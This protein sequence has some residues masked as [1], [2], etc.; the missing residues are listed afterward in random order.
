MEIRARHKV[1]IQCD[2]DI[3]SS[4][5]ALHFLSYDMEQNPSF[6]FFSPEFAI[7]PADLYCF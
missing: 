4:S 5:N 3:I 6:F 2:P 7:R 1:I